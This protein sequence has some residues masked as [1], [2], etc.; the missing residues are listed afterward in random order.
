MEVGGKLLPKNKRQWGG[1]ARKGQWE[2]A[3]TRYEYV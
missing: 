3:K 2:C 1:R